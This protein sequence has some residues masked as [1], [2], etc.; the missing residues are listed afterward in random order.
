MAKLTINQRLAKSLA[1][2][3]GLHEWSLSRLAEESGISRGYLYLLEKG[4]NS[5]TLEMLEKIADAFAIPM[6]E[7]LADADAFSELT[8]NEYALVHAYRN[9]NLEKLLHMIAPLA[10]LKE[11]SDAVND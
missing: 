2:Y 10:A 4:E 9:G 5:P 1:Q 11:T 6:W 3:R 8:P 7:L